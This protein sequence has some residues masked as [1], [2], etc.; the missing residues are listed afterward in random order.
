MR[1]NGQPCGHAQPTE[2]ERDA[3]QPEK[4]SHSLGQLKRRCAGGSAETHPAP[5]LAPKQCKDEPVVSRPQVLQCARIHTSGEEATQRS[6]ST[7]GQQ[8]QGR[9]EERGPVQRQEAAQLGGGTPV[10]LWCEPGCWR[11]RCPPHSRPFSLATLSSSSDAPVRYPAGFWLAQAHWSRHMSST[12]SLA[13]HLQRQPGRAGRCDVDCQ[14]ARHGN[15]AAQRSH[16]ARQALAGQ[17]RLAW[18]GLRHS[19]APD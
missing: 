10:G 8:Q 19:S 3:Q 12:S 9:R 11:A 6:S 17:P 7:H 5:A 13:F 15:A 14:R 2:G 16:N 1:P 4:P 18:P